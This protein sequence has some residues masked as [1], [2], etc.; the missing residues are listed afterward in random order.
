MP[1]WL[2]MGIWEEN[3]FSIQGMYRC[4]GVHS[5][6]RSRIYLELI[7]SGHWNHTISHTSYVIDSNV[8]LPDCRCYNRVFIRGTRGINLNEDT[9]RNGRSNWI[10]LHKWRYIDTNKMYL[11]YPT[12]STLLFQVIHQ[13]NYPQGIIQTIQDCPLS[14]IHSKW[15]RYCDSHNICRNVVNIIGEYY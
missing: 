7:T 8:V 1:N 12:S 11:R 14:I 10:I 6:P 15:T 3:I 4:K 13:E 9:R 2:K 5:N